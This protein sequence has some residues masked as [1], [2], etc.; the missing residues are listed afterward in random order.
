MRRN[1]VNSITYGALFAALVGVLVYIN[2]L[3]AN[4]IDIYFFW[5]IPVI[6]V[7]YRCKF[8]LRD[9][10]LTCFAML[11]LTLV[12]AGPISTSTFYVAASVV[13]GVTYGEG[14]MKGKSAMFLIGSVI[15]VSL[16]V[17]LLSTFV[18]AGFFGYN[19]TDDIAFMHQAVNSY[20]EM[21]KD[22]NPQAGEYLL[23]AFTDNALMTIIILSS[24]L[25]SILEGILVHLLTYIVL[26]KLKMATLPPVKPVSEIYC[27]KW[28]KFVIFVILFTGLAAKVSGINTYDQIIQPLEMIAYIICFFFG[29]IFIATMLALR[30]AQTKKRRMGLSLLICLFCL[31]FSPIV[32]AMGLF[33]I[34]SNFRRKLIEELK[35]NAEQQKRQA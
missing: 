23:K 25:S 19:L 4:M 3:T 7:V 18:F 24:I 10:L 17:M 11:L 31:F 2:R 28:L 29:Y 33:D 26:K 35:K 1:G 14:L 15:A 16:V 6:I 8:D 34:Y 12:L 32:I 20:A 22:V 30:N 9:T 13:A 27:P 21:V 5:I